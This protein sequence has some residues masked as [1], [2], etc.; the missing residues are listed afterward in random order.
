MGTLFVILLGSLPALLL[1]AA[2]AFGRYPGAR[3]LDRLR[4][5]TKNPA[6]RHG[7]A[8]PR[9]PRHLHVPH[10]IH[11]GRLIA[12]SMAGRAPPRSFAAAA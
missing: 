9:K 4:E 7:S 11:G 8:P 6:P 5:S 3:A 12:V 10:A 1:F 2:L